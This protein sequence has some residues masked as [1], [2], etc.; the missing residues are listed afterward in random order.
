[1]SET[2]HRLLELAQ[3]VEQSQ[4]MLAMS[5][6]FLACSTSLLL[7]LIKLRFK[8]DA[9]NFDELKAHLTPNVIDNDDNGWEECVDAAMTHLLRTVLAKSRAEGNANRSNELAMPDDTT[10]L[11]KHISIVCD[12]LHKGAKLILD[13]DADD[14]GAGGGN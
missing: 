14:D 5:Q 7:L 13:E 4:N 1:M 11:K 12:R 9:A 2:Y 6:N 3:H 10:K 8:L